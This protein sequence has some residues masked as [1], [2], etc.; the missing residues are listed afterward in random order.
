MSKY[1]AVALCLASLNAQGGIYIVDANGGSA[2][3]FTDIQAAVLAVPDHSTLVVQPGSYAPVDIAAKGITILC[4]PKVV[5]PS[6][7]PFL[8]IRNTQPQQAVT[9]AGLRGSGASGL[10]MQSAQGPVTHDG[11]GHSTCPR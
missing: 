3:N 11:I 5:V 4:A 2:A 7:G 6:P 8:T 9:V 10:L 1:V